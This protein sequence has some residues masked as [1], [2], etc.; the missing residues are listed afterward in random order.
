MLNRVNPP[1]FVAYAQKLQV[2]LV[3]NFVYPVGPGNYSP[4]VV[5]FNAS[6][7]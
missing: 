1:V 4:E 5:L 7:K 3:G 6:K 2:N